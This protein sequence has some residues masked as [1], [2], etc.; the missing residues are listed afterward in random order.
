MVEVTDQDLEEKAESL[1]INGSRSTG[2]IPNSEQM[3]QLRL[4]ENWQAKA[5]YR[6]KIDGYCSNSA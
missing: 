3:R 2:P 5:D 1:G 4:I 6:A